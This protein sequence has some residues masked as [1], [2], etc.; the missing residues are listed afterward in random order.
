MD[1]FHHSHNAA[2]SSQL[3]RRRS[4]TF[5]SVLFILI[6]LVLGVVFAYFGSEVAE[7]DSQ[8]FDLLVVQYAKELRTN[9]LWLAE[10]LR[11]LSGVGSTVVLTL[12]TLGCVGY[13]ALFRSRVTAALVATSVITGTLLVS[14][15]KALFGRARPDP[16]Y[17]EFVVSGMSFPSGHS[18][19]SAL[20]FLTIGVV[21]ANTRGQLGEKIY[22]L[23][24]AGFLSTLVGLS[25]VGLGVHWA[26]DVIAGWS[27]G[28]AWAI[29]W[30]VIAHWL[31]D[32]AK[33]Q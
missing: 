25:R 22:I 17:A 12:L 15:F 31:L 3:T 19:M 21:I 13:Q 24:A 27:F 5:N 20:V 2:A 10:V 33:R 11:D 4:T 18:T 8:A 16:S 9:H 26:T 28:G 6:A 30:L 23:A 14:L 7:G 29:L 1:R 32:R